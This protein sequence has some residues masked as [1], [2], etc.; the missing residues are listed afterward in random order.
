MKLLPGHLPSILPFSLPKTPALPRLIH[1]NFRRQRTR[2]ASGTALKIVDEEAWVDDF[3]LVDYGNS[4]SSGRERSLIPLS[5]TNKEGALT[6]GRRDRSVRL[7]SKQFPK[8][9]CDSE[10]VDIAF[11]LSHLARS[12]VVSSSQHGTTITE[13]GDYQ[14]HQVADLVDTTDRRGSIRT[15]L[16]LADP[17][18]IYSLLSRFI[19]SSLTSYVDLLLSNISSPSFSRSEIVFSA[20]QACTRKLRHSHLKWIPTLADKLEDGLF[21]SEGAVTK[22][23]L[24]GI[25][26]AYSLGHLSDDSNRLIQVLRTYLTRHAPS[27]DRVDRSIILLAYNL[28]MVLL[29]RGQVSSS[30]DTFDILVKNRLIALPEYHLHS[31]TTRPISEGSII[32]PSILRS[33]YTKQMTYAIPSVLER[34]QRWLNSS[35]SATESWESVVNQS[36]RLVVSERKLE[37]VRKV[38]V[39]LIY[40]HRDVKRFLDKEVIQ[41]LYKVAVDSGE[42][43]DQVIELGRLYTPPKMETMLLVAEAFGNR[44][45]LNEIAEASG[46]P[47]QHPQGLNPIA[48]SQRAWISARL[49]EYSGVDPKFGPSPQIMLALIHIGAL[50]RV[51]YFYDHQTEP[52]ATPTP[53]PKTSQLAT[54]L[55]TSFATSDPPFAKRVLDDSI[56]SGIFLSPHQMFRA[57][58]A[59]NQLDLVFQSLRSVLKE[60]DGETPRGHT[61]S[62][63]SP[64]RSRSRSRAKLL[65]FPTSTDLLNLLSVIFKTNH[66]SGIAL[67][68]YAIQ[69]GALTQLSE[70]K[71][72]EHLVASLTR[73][74]DCDCCAC[75]WEQDDVATFS[76]I[77]DTWH[78]S[79]E[80]PSKRANTIC[81]LVES[82]L[83]TTTRTRT[84]TRTRTKTKEMTVEDSKV[85]QDDIFVLRQMMKEIDL[86]RPRAR[87]HARDHARAQPRIGPGNKSGTEPDETS[88]AVVQ[89]PTPIPTT[90]QTS[91][92]TPHT[93][94]TQTLLL[95][96]WT[97]LTRAHYYLGGGLRAV[98]DDL[99]MAKKILGEE[100][101]NDVVMKVV[102]EG[103]KGEG[104]LG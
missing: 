42:M 18:S 24:R 2:A 100:A 1:P 73:D 5:S 62:A 6:K 77:I 46:V 19:D 40:N 22:R 44:S 4:R 98:N 61:Y 69:S 43:L 82:R 33:I 66:R 16:A 36:I 41:E 99:E 47:R 56:S 20:L 104:M 48:A 55:V 88:E 17:S 30:A 60:E 14:I 79:Y 28:L 94:P 15:L 52:T 32:W 91:P 9:S 26:T 59:T 12:D 102:Q 72:I 76:N 21:T 38:G 86:E 58:V 71:A 75:F 29:E 65:S 84:R 87:A 96:L 57:Y 89:T 67:F 70:I 83:K 74:H 95:R 25:M 7:L 53:T 103:G 64:S 8:P 97:C 23:M 54:A 39:W 101:A 34:G 92:S 93:R 10:D 90:P 85:T 45:L 80:T 49:C 51:R 35:G 11:Y 50:D 31:K 78:E 27:P 81:R 63:P 3:P 68:E 37:R 13:I